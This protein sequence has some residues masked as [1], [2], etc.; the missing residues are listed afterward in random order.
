M[1][2]HGRVTPWYSRNQCNIVKQLYSNKK[3]KHTPNPRD[4]VSWRTGIE[5]SGSLFQ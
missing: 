3:A 2:T 1:Y 4:I 5:N